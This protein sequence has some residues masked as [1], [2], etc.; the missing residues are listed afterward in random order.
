MA[1]AEA[2][3][4]MGLHERA[5]ARIAKANADRRTAYNAKVTR[6]KA[7]ADLLYKMGRV[8]MPP[9]PEKPKG[10]GAPKLSPT[11]R[12]TL[13]AEAIANGTDKFMGKTGPE[14]AD[15]YLE[16][17]SKSGAAHTGVRFTGPDKTFDRQVKLR[18]LYGKD[19]QLKSLADSLA[20]AQLGTDQE[21]IDR[22]K[23]AISEREKALEKTLPEVPT[24]GKSTP[25]PKPTTQSTAPTLEQFMKA[26]R[27]APQNK[28]IS[29]EE[30]RAYY[31][32]TYGR[33]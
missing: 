33:K 3:Q 17:I 8:S 10:S 7:E 20:L 21:R 18:E 12:I 23:T 14:A 1:K 25:T 2:D 31:Q 9:A 27:A 22:L 28:G 32:S 4:R 13:K 24:S 6:D 29:D 15:A 26:A 19:P 30:L 5:E 16:S 11:E